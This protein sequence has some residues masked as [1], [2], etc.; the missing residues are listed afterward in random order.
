MKIIRG[1]EN[2]ENH[3]PCLELK[4][5][6]KHAQNIDILKDFNCNL[7]CLVTTNTF[8]SKKTTTLRKSSTRWNEYL[9]L[10]LPKNLESEWLRIIIYDA[11]PITPLNDISDSYNNNGSSSNLN[12]GGTVQ[13]HPQNSHS[14]SHLS[15]SKCHNHIHG[16]SHSISEVTLSHLNTHTDSTLSLSS[17]TSHT[18]SD[19]DIGPSVEMNRQDERYLYLGEVRLSLLDLFKKKYSPTSY[20][21][22]QDPEWYELCDR[23]RKKQMNG[24]HRNDSTFQIGELQLGF[25]LRSLSKRIST[26]EAYNELKSNLKFHKETLKSMGEKRDLQS[27]INQKTATDENIKSPLQHFIQSNND[28]T[29]QFDPDGY[30]SYNDEDDSDDETDEEIVEELLSIDEDYKS[31]DNN[32]RNFLS[33]YDILSEVTSLNESITDEKQFDIGSVVTALDEYDVVDHND[34]E[35]IHNIYED[36]FSQI[37]NDSIVNNKNTYL[38]EGRQLAISDYGTKVGSLLRNNVS[39]MR[40]SED[41]SFKYESSEN[42]IDEE[43]AEY[44][45]DDIIMHKKKNPLVKLRGKQRSRQLYRSSLA[46]RLRNNYRLTKRIHAAG[47]IFI[48]L[49][50]IKNLPQLKNKIS[51]TNYEM[52]PFI[53]ATFGRRVFKSS[54]KKHTLNPVYNERATFE[55]FPHETHF[56]FQFKV[57]DKDSFSSNDNIAHCTLSWHDMIKYQNSEHDW[58]QYDIPLELNVNPLVKGKVDPSILC[59]RIKF[60]SYDALKKYFW[61]N[62]VNMTAPSETFDIVQLLMYL[63]TFGSFSEIEGENFFT[64]SGLSPWSGNSITKEQ[65]IEVLQQWKN[66]S[67]FKH[68]WKCPRCHQSFKTNR[69]TRNSK[70]ILENDL[71][72]HFAVCTYS[73][74]HKL[75]EPS[76]VSTDFASKKW[77]TKFFIKLTY[78]KYALGSNNANILVQDRVSG[79]IIEEKI[80][81]HVKLGMRIIYNGKGTETKK[82]KALLKRMSVR[83]GKKFDSPSSVKQIVPFIKFHSLDMTQCKETNF[84][85]FNDFFY[86]KLKDGSRLPEGPTSKTFICPADSRSLFFPNITESKK[87]W[88]KGSQFTLKRLTNNYKPDIFNEKTCSISIFRLAPQDYHRF[89]SPCDGII[90]EPMYI[91]GEYFTV[92]P[93]AIRSSLD[94][95]GE[96]VRV[97]LPIES[98]EFGYI[99]VIAVGAMMVGS[100]ILTCEEG[101]SI[102]RGQELGYFKFGGST[103]ITLIPS[104]NI[105]FDSDLLKNSSE[106]IET[107]VRVGMS[108]GHTPDI[109]EIMRKTVKP[110]NPEQL[111]SIKRTISVSDA[112][113][114]SLGNVTWQYAALQSWLSTKYP[115]MSEP[116]SIVEETESN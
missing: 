108:V 107:L 78:G 67:G 11:L 95:F 83:Q 60:I 102:K 99:L 31:D 40:N 41:E 87:L 26:F 105:Q 97:I 113:S 19:S 49:I 62:A 32:L 4:I 3:K 59:L 114:T 37:N 100:I 111:E 92:N 88:I 115:T 38:H 89:H 29:Q 8:Y 45:T 52:D 57:I 16:E 64:R 12:S 72:T 82:F 6:V 51:R 10:K 66:I 36:E 43:G 109:K 110:T 48:D 46:R 13:S 77:F 30:E 80:S 63:N 103:I 86:R 56:A 98:P 53:I 58:H 94:V 93:M 61:V 112:N 85:T 91:E 34:M 54:W 22:L 20:N 69:N 75:L 47:V 68:V 76:Y 104:K 25:Q 15:V 101:N 90:G 42:E 14:T 74:K 73:Q 65:L 7:V 35:D 39:A 21:F 17:T 84:K 5:L 79:I 1:K 24:S 116:S 2:K 55:V 44:E 81:A 28:K 50:D 96:N 33:E 106:R 27:V 23:Q 18:P 9:K 70:L 71:I